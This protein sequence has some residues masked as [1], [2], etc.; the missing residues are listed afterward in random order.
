MRANQI[1]TISQATK[2][3]IITRYGT[4]GE[5]ITVAYPGVSSVFRARGTKHREKDPYV[6][7]VA[8]L[9]RGK[10]IPLA[11]RALTP[12]HRL[13]IAGSTYWLDPEI[14]RTIHELKARKRVK[15]MGFVSDRK[16]SA[17]YR[18]ATAVLVPSFVEGFCLPVVEAMASGTPVI[19]TNAGSLPEIV[20]KAGI[21]AA[22]TEKDFAR[23]MHAVATRPALRSALVREGIQRSNLFRWD[24]F[25]RTVLSVIN[26]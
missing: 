14:E 13:L 18:G 12:P 11:I 2:Q 6:L 21:V 24:R 3:D 1:I 22:A 4:P 5:R 9:K 25:A 8:S 17:L 20:G 10:N 26:T 19:A 23:A 7:I 15:F 16:L